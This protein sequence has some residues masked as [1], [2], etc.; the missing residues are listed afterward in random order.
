MLLSLTKNTIRKSFKV[1][2]LTI[3]VAAIF[4]LLII[5]ITAVIKHKLSYVN[6]LDFLGLNT[7]LPKYENSMTAT[8]MGWSSLV[9]LFCNLHYL[10]ARFYTFKIRIK[11][12]YLTKKIANILKLL[13]PK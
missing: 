11:S 3:T 2:L 4:H 1:L 12:Y 5:T 9:A 6:P 13:K 7:I 8:T 10:Y